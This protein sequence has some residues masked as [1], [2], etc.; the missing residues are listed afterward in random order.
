MLSASPIRVAAFTSGATVPGARFRVRQYIPALA[1]AGIAVTEHWPRLSA[2]P[3]RAKW[4]RPAWFAGTLAQRLS[5]IALAQ[6]VD[7]TWLYRE[8]ISTLV[9]FEGLT[10][11]PRLLDVDDSIHLFRDGN[12]ARRLARMVDLVVVS[13]PYLADAWRRWT[14]HVEVLPMAVDTDRITPAPFPSRPV[15]GWLGSPPNLPYLVGIAPALAAVTARFPGTTVAVCSEQQPLLPGLPIRYVPWSPMAERPFLD[16]LSIGIVPLADTPWERGKFSYKMLLYMAAG[17]PVVGSPV[18][19]GADMLYGHN[20]GIAAADHEQWV[21]ALSTL[22]AD[23]A[24]MQRLGSEGRLVAVRD[25]SVSAVAPR[26]A[27]ILHRLAA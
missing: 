27:K 24:A 18:G 12:T 22:L 14:P 23:Q 26:L 6:N 3:P 15:I 9:T 16:S 17:R 10:R 5:Q 7:V 8:L 2:F 4:L 20:V 13:S 21:A 19:S 11:Q 1:Q 25:Y